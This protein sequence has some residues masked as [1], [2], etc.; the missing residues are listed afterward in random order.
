M[1]APGDY[2][3]RMRS[4][5][6]AVL[7]AVPLVA[8]A[9]RN[10]RLVGRWRSEG[11]ELTER[12]PDAGTSENPEEL[13]LE[14]KAD[15]TGTRAGQEIR[16]STEPG[17]L[18][19]LSKPWCGTG[20]LESQLNEFR[21]RAARPYWLEGDL[22]ELG[23]HGESDRNKWRRV[24]PPP[25]PAAASPTQERDRSLVDA[26]VRH[27]WCPRPAPDSPADRRRIDLFREDGRLVRRFLRW[28]KNSAGQHAWMT[29]GSRET[30]WKH[31]NGTLS[32]FD[33]H[34][35]PAP[36]SVEP[37]SITRDEYGIP[38]LHIGKDESVP[39]E[40]D[41]APPALPEKPRK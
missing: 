29:D 23:W 22:L 14:L 31:E 41:E 2:A 13:L 18:V 25:R 32:E 21:D 30:F 40:R 16:W 20:L 28:K 19:I 6:A 12:V 26:L 17:R 11:G 7:V 3:R 24:E 35:D 8:S 33:H 4:L 27:E 37:I 36:W 38:H 1:S 34:P 9:D 15:G 5:V 10:E 39:C